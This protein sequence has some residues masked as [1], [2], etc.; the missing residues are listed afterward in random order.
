MR[1]TIAD[2]IA[3]RYYGTFD[4]LCRKHNVVFTAQATGNAQCIVAI[5]IV[6]KS[7]VQKPQGE[8][9]VM[10]PDGNYDIK[11]SSSAAHLYGKPIASAEAF[12]DG[13][14]TTMPSDLKNI[15]DGAYAFGINEFVVC[16]SVHQPR[17]A[18]AGDP[19]GRY[20]A[21]YSRNNTWWEKSRDFWNYQARVSYVMR[22]G[23]SVADLCCISTEYRHR[24]SLAHYIADTCLV[25]PKVPALFPP[26]IVT[27]IGCIISSARITGICLTRLM[28]RSTDYKLVNAE[29]ICTVCDILQI[30][31][32]SGQVTIGKSLGRSYRFA[33][34]VCCR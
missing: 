20:Y 27:R 31:W 23:R 3:E 7:K 30:T 9:W 29:G 18:N 13:D 4:R 32:H 16:A 17:E 5:S 33:V 15:A 10:Q 19:G 26:C 8:F 21:T 22:Q 24:P 34:K 1:L 2:L 25:I 14:L 6:A 28:H 12:T 11:E